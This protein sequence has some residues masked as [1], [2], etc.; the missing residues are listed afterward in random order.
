MQNQS[1]QMADL[2]NQIYELQKARASD[3]QALQ[4]L[5][6]LD[7]SISKLLDQSFHTYDQKHNKKLDNL[8]LIRDNKNREMYNTITDSLIRSLS[9]EVPRQLLPILAAKLDGM[10]Q[11]MHQDITVKMSSTDVLVRENVTKLCTNQVRLQF[12]LLSSSPPLSR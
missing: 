4:N 3:T 2:R 12:F 8:M 7:S 11:Q 1:S 5:A 6:S 9:S 10:K